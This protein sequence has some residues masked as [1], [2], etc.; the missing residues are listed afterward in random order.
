M[1]D[2][3]Y[4]TDNHGNRH[5]F[6]NE[7]HAYLDSP[8][9]TER[10]DHPRPEPDDSWR[11]AQAEFQ[12]L[13]SFI[14]A[15]EAR[16]MELIA[17]WG[18]DLTGGDSHVNW[19]AWAAGVKPSSARARVKAAARLQALPKI[20]AAF[21]AGEIS[22]D[23]AET[24]SKIATEDTEEA[25]LEM[26]KDG[27]AAQMQQVAGALVRATAGAAGATDQAHQDRALTYYFTD[28]GGFRL[29]AQLGAEDGA[30]VAEAIKAAAE[31][32]HEQHKT[33][34]DQDVSEKR[35]ADHGDTWP[36]READALV[37]LSESFLA[38][39][40]GSRTGS[41]RHEIVIHVDEAALAG[42]LAGT[43]ET[44][45]GVGMSPEAVT[46]I[47]C[48]C[49][50]RILLERDKIELNLSRK[51]RT[52]SPG[53]R[54]AIVARDCHC[55]FPGCTARVYVDCHHVEHWVRDGGETKPENL[56]LLCRRHHRLLHEGRYSMTFDGKVATFYREDGSVVERA[57]TYRAINEVEL[58][59]AR[60]VI[61]VDPDTWAHWIDPIDV[62]CAVGWLCDTEDERE[63]RDREAELEQERQ[64]IRDDERQEELVVS[65]A[66]GQPRAGPD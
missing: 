60:A 13:S 19:F 31:Q 48:D 55:Q 56:V 46:R 23:K 57:P 2:S 58:A 9:W 63:R 12:E 64:Q 49:S 7:R 54:R 51:R 66:G 29:R 47:A 17:T 45:S 35:L 52:V 25:L 6:G 43:A 32:L 16:R 20:K 38:T 39:G 61:A 30:I 62:D 53:L 34:A 4:L 18:D 65:G 40:L 41:E 14:A 59:E 22:F 42:E 10:G 28:E 36:Q 50:F 33:F 37:A 21:G 11:A 27:L 44:E 1:F 15:A 26:A 5:R 8:S 24:I 3:G